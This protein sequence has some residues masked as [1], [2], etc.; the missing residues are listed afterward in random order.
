MESLLDPS[1]SGTEITTPLLVPIHS[2]PELIRSA[3][4]RTSE[5]PEIK[6]KILKKIQ[7]ILFFEF[8][9]DIFYY[10]QYFIIYYIFLYI[11]IFIMIYRCTYFN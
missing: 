3:V 5:K 7:N 1:D 6:V 2:R 4:M 10:R 8:C 11:E 9:I